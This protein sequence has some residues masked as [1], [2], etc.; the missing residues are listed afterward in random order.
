MTGGTVSD[1]TEAV[2]LITGLKA[3]YLLADK[4]YDSEEIVSFS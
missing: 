4:G 1:Y 2:P 3:E